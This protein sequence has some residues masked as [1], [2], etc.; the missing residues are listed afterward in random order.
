MPAPRTSPTTRP[1]RWTQRLAW[2]LG[3]GLLLGGMLWVML[4]A[5]TAVADGVVPDAPQTASGAFVKSHEG[6]QPD[7]D[8]RP[9]AQGTP[10]TSDTGPL[11]YGELRRLF[12]YYLSAQGEQNLVAITQQIQTELDRRLNAAQAKKA[13]RLLDLYLSF[14][15]ALVDLEAKPGL[16]GNG[17]DAIR[18]RMLAQQDLRT[19]YFTADE[20]EGMF[21]FEDAMD[22]DAVARLEVSQNPKLSAAQKHKQLAALDAAMSPTLRAEREASLA[23]VRMEQRATD[24]RAQGASD[25]EIYRMRAQAFDA[26]AASRLADLDKEEADWK[27]RIAVYLE[28]RSQVLKSQA[29]ASPGERQQALAQLQQSQFSEDERRRL[30]AYE[31]Q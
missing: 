8:L 7:G 18:Q 22:A 21:G 9:A 27:R 6:T 15:R 19:Q 28:A 2:G 5:D 30:A 4:R 12:D 26:G 3:A 25:D 23:V 10:G 16:A 1:S 20:I 14:R 13:R 17:V 11:A 29:N 31:P 24:M